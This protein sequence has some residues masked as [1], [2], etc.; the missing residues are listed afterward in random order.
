M[1]KKY[2]DENFKHPLK[3]HLNVILML[4]PVSNKIELV[5]NLHQKLSLIQQIGD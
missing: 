3:N 1:L 4:F 5:K 2:F